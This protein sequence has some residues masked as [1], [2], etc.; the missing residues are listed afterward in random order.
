M[1]VN[2]VLN[3][4]SELQKQGKGSYAVILPR[5]LIDYEASRVEARTDEE[6]V[7]IICQI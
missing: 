5:G 1:T 2:D 3:K 7:D 4:L 6:K